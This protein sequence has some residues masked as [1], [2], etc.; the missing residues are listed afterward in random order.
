MT[1][2]RTKQE[3]AQEHQSHSNEQS[4]TQNTA[5]QHRP[6]W[7]IPDNGTSSR[8]LNDLEERHGTRSGR[9]GNSSIPMDNEDTL[10]IP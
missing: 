5:Q 10:G 6:D 9:E 3:D 7:I 2:D 1:P 4:S 8:N